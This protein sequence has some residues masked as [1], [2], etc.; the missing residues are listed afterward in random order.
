MCVCVCVYVFGEGNNCV[1]MF[2]LQAV[3]SPNMVKNVEVETFLNVVCVCVC[4]FGLYTA[5]VCMNRAIWHASVLLLGNLCYHA[6]YMDD[7]LW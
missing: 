1:L 3:V 7:S 5:P 6:I 2:C 4:V